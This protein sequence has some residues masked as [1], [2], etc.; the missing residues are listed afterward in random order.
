MRSLVCLI[1]L[2]LAAAL[3]L[4]PSPACCEEDFYD[5]MPYFLQV[6]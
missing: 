1:A 4:A 6:T 3:A 2:T 5:A